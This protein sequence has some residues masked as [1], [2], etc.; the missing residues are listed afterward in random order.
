LIFSFFTYFCYNYFEEGMKE[1]ITILYV[2]DEPI[3][4]KIF[5]INFRK[6][7]NVIVSS[8]GYIGLEK[9]KQHLEIK[10]VISDMKMPEMNGIE[11]IKKARKE[12]PGVFYFILTGYDINEE[13]SHAL[14]Q[15]IINQYF[16]KPFN[17][18]EIE[19]SIEEA[20]ESQ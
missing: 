16:R 18:K 1:K 11:F 3:N 8:S 13:I 5:E 15:K 10:V 9:L 2:D 12:F 14:D 4:L 19:K 6:K 20:I 7:F 17:M